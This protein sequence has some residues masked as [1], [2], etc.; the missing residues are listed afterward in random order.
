MGLIVA[1][2]CAAATD[3]NYNSM[4]TL[5]FCDVYQ[6]YFR[7][8]T[9]ER[10]A[11]WVLRISTLLCGGLSIVIALA[12]INSKS[13]LDAWWTLAGIFSGGMLGLFL[14]GLIFRRITSRAAAVSLCAGVL[15]V[16]WM[17]VSLSSFS[18]VIPGW[19]WPGTLAWLKSPFDGLMIPVIGTL[20]ILIVGLMI[21]LIASPRADKAAELVDVEST[22]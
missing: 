12:M 6:R 22:R 7:P 18:G 17:T 9:S 2:I 15:V 1:A 14:L 5:I 4:A 11:M 20:T 3:S 8:R 13:I 16:L 21:G 10:E 19:G